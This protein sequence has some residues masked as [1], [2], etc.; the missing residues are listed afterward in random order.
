MTE[1][2]GRAYTVNSTG[3]SRKSCGT[4]GVYSTLN[5]SADWTLELQIRAKAS[6][7]KVVKLFYS[8]GPPSFSQKGI[9]RRSVEKMCTFAHLWVIKISPW[10]L[11]SP[12]TLPQLCPHHSRRHPRQL[13]TGHW[14]PHINL[15]WQRCKLLQCCN[16]HPQPRKHW[17]RSDAYGSASWL[18]S[19]VATGRVKMSNCISWLSGV[20][21][22]P[23]FFQQIAYSFGVHKH[24][25]PI[26]VIL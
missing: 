26:S 15:H 11:C 17:T 14:G 24:S 22:V 9:V 8:V 2:K 16:P 6:C 13:H 3:L 18:K 12:W 19:Y 7:G 21:R 25:Q 20:L 1:L 5:L 4:S 23:N 10:S